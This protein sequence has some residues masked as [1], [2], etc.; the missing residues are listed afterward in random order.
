MKFNGPVL[1]AV[2]GL[3]AGVQA[4]NVSNLTPLDLTLPHSVAARVQVLSLL[5]SHRDDRM[6]AL[7]DLSCIIEPF[8]WKLTCMRPSKPVSFMYGFA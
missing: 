7:F 3:C 6:Q 4:F 5:L 8:S 1:A 2:V